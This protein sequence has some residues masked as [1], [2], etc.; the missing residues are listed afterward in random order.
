MNA[1]K[2]SSFRGPV[3]ALAAALT[4]AISIPGGKL[5]LGHLGSFTLAGSLYLGGGVA[6]TIYRIAKRE[7]LIVEAADSAGAM[8][9]GPSRRS[10]VALS[11]A[12]ICGGMLAP[13][14]LYWGLNHLNAAT[15]SLLLSLEVVF[16]ALLAG[17]LF[18]EQVAKQV[19][20]AVA[21]M[22]AASVLLSWTGRGL[23][24]SVYALA[25]AGA[26]F[27]WGLDS[28]LLREARGFSPAFMGQ[29]RGLVAGSANLLIGA[30][31]LHERL[32]V[33]YALWGALLGVFS[34]G[35]SVLLYVY[36]LRRLGSA[37]S[38]AYFSSAPLFAAVISLIV[39]VERPGWRV[40]VAFALVVVATI[41]MVL[42][43]HTHE[44]SHGTL[45]H[46]HAHWPDEEHRH[47]H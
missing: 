7:P 46:T 23:S 34:C 20:I 24:W 11:L 43:R 37:R 3:L 32:D 12:T 30:L 47:K 15:G 26:T 28:N 4:F 5:L 18:R 10:I 17:L 36:A 29:V 45:V 19:W 8:Q 1:D 44:H 40:F 27:F 16:T 13:S 31:L 22:V 21:L 25:V 33:P 35:L 9:N 2:N 14:L 41:T 6:S 38:G 42:E 39:F